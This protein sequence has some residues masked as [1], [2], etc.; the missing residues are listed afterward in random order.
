MRLNIVIFIDKK[1][2]YTCRQLSYWCVE[3][4]SINNLYSVEPGELEYKDRYLSQT[5]NSSFMFCH[6]NLQYTR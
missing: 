5:F 4:Y 2:C 1:G 6:F 3:F